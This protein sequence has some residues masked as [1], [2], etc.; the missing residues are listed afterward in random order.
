[1]AQENPAFNKRILLAEKLNDASID[2]VMGLDTDLRIIS[3]NKMCEQIFDAPADTVLSRPLTDVF[4][5]L[6][7]PDKIAEALNLALAGM[8]SFVPSKESTLGDSYSECHII[9]LKE[10][11]D[12]VTGILLIR[13]DVAHRV[14]AELE[15]ERLNASLARKN[16]E[17]E[18]RNSELLSF[19][20]VT[21]HDLK[22]PLRKIQMFTN[23]LL[24]NETEHLT[25][26]GRSYFTRIQR[27][28]S[29]METLTDDMFTFAQINETTEPETEV[30]LDHVL[31]FVENSFRETI[32]DK[33]AVIVSETLPVIRGHRTLLYVLFQNLIGNSLK[34]THDGHSP[35]ITI[36]AGNMEG[37][38]I[39]HPD[40]SGRTTY[41]WVG[42]TDKGIGFDPTYKDLIFEMFQR[43]DPANQYS[44]NGIGLAI[45]RKI[46]VLH[47]GFITAEST[48]GKGSRFTCYFP[49]EVPDRALAAWQ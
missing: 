21:S 28:T 44:G 4:P 29:K 14:K 5:H 20:H 30:T 12:Q 38:Q 34:F 49:D 15:L 11:D 23:M 6:K 7:E 9:P 18:E 16:R 46:A 19:A 45:C 25:E 10:A 41:K 3:W 36:D 27:A 26:K 22:E 2:C 33:Q 17:L 24:D 47:R 40:A 43:L 42:I 48:A 39:R 37:R 1:M 13:H 31:K 8:Q 35:H 32:A